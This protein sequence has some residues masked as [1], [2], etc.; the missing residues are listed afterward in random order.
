MPEQPILAIQNTVGGEDLAV[1]M[2]TLIFAQ[3]IIASVLNSA[4]STV[5]SS[6]LRS[7]IPKYAPS[8]DPEAVIEAGATGL[9]EVVPASELRAVLRGYVKAI[10]QVYY[11][12]LAS[13]GICV[14]IVWGLG[15]R[16]VRQNPRGSRMSFVI[17]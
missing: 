6:G 4:A 11:V 9:R 7:Q 10:D 2:S 3:N 17:A 13:F 14:V 16:D 15:W 8:I 12:T 1:G 5:F